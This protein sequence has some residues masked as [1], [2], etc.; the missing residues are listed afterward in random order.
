MAMLTLA[1]KSAMISRAAILRGTTMSI[2]LPL[3]TPGHFGL[4]RHPE[5]RC[6]GAAPEDVARLPTANAL[7]LPSPAMRSTSA[8][9][10]VSPI[11]PTADAF[12]N[13]LGAVAH[14]GAT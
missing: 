7:S 14:L 1:C 2:T 3:T 13:Q 9:T 6:V 12:V 10:E 8:G 5:R 11:Q 4:A